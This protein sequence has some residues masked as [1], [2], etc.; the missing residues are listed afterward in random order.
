MRKTIFITGILM[1]ILIL[2]CRLKELVDDDVS[3]MEEDCITFERLYDFET[4]D[5]NI[6]DITRASDGNFIIC[7]S[8]SEDIFLMKIDEEGTTLFAKVDT[9]PGTQEKCN[10]VITTP[11]GGF[12]ICA[13]RESQAFFV[14]YDIE[15]NHQNQS[16]LPEVSRCDCIINSNDGNYIYSG[17][18]KHNNGINNTYVGRL[19][20]NNTF[21]E[22][23]PGY[24]PAPPRE[25][26]ERAHSIVA[27]PGGYAIAGHSYNYQDGGNG[28]AVHF[29]RLDNDLKIVPNSERFHHLGTQQD[30]AKGIVA[31]N[32]DNFLIT[33]DLEKG[34]GIDA[35][36]FKVNQNGDSLQ[37]NQYGQVGRDFG[38]DIIAAHESNH[39]II[40]GRST[41]FGNGS[42][43]IYL[44]KIDDNGTLVWEKTFGQPDADEFSAAVIRAD[45]DCGYIVAGYSIQSNQGRP[46]II[47]VD[48]D[49]NIQ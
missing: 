3:P 47:R 31:I 11:D 18:I 16:T 8:T 1:L 12:L 23:L 26:I 5:L 40:C 4:P 46:Y 22:L 21:P 49:G 2:G 41:S 25:G 33:G 45:D 9:I 42:D 44:L 36:A 15:G 10:A 48:E 6:T 38:V 35:F 37:L 30:I 19:T 14:K 27:I 32:N 39:Y 34:Q 43:D 28:T 17:N 24:L 13:Q 7:G 29:Y 20:L